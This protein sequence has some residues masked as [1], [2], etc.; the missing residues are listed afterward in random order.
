MFLSCEPRRN[1]DNDNEESESMG[2]DKD[3]YCAVH[4]PDG[5]VKNETAVCVIM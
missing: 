3:E 2:D 1:D 4:K 5:A